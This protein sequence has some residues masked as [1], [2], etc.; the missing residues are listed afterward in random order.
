MKCAFPVKTEVSLVQASMNS[1]TTYLIVFKMGVAKWLELLISDQE[2]AGL[3]PPLHV[4]LL[5]TT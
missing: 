2:V 5:N 4:C 3:N 1:V